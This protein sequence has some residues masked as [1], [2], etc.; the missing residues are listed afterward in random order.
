MGWGQVL[1]EQFD[2][3]RIEILNRALG[4]RSSRTFLTEGL[5]DKLL[6]EARTGDS[7]LIQFGHNDGGPLDEG[8]AR[9]SLKGI[10]GET[11][12][13]TNQANGKVETVQ[14]FGGYLRHYVTTAREKGVEPILVSLVP[15]TIW[16]DGK[17]VRSTNDCGLWTSQ[18]ARELKVEF[19]DLNALVAD[20]YDRLGKEAVDKLFGGDHTHTNPEG[21]RLNA[22]CVAEGL[23]A[24][25]RTPLKQLLNQPAPQS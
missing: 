14:A 21:A 8:R 17:V 16:K 15:R 3:N 9:A 19:I 4:G 10:S 20:R 13:I 1:P 22:A 25:K 11:R 24:L 6:T 12:V 2:T 7:V 18:V 23:R 5:W